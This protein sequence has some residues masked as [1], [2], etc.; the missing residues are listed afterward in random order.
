MDATTLALAK[1]YTDKKFSQAGGGI[2][3]SSIIVAN[4]TIVDGDNVQ[5]DV[6]PGTFIDAIRSGKNG[7]VFLTNEDGSVSSFTGW[8]SKSNYFAD[9][10]LNLFYS[11]NVY[12]NEVYRLQATRNGGG[13]WRLNKY[14]VNLIQDSLF[15]SVEGR[16]VQ[17]SEGVFKYLPGVFTGETSKTTAQ[18][19]KEELDDGKQV[20]M[21]VNADVNYFVNAWSYDPNYNCVVGFIN[22]IEEEDTQTKYIFTCVGNCTTNSWSMQK[23]PLSVSGTDTSLPSVTSEDEGKVAMVKDGKWTAQLLSPYEEAVFYANS[24]G[25]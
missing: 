13:K 2:D 21:V 22:V 8:Y 4:A 11:G 9:S 19:V 7:T 3:E 16:I 25:T 12:T 1:K 14:Y 10:G 23:I 20:N 5:C 17:V 18:Q 15:K 6:L 24:S